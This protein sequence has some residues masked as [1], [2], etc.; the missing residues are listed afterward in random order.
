MSP[1]AATSTSS[2]DMRSDLRQS[3]NDVD[4]HSTE[5]SRRP[6]LQEMNTGQDIEKADHSINSTHPVIGLEKPIQDPNLVDFDGPEDSGNPKNWSVRKRGAATVSMGL[7]TFVVTFASSVFSVAI[8]HVAVEYNIGTVT[9]TLG[10]SLFLLGFVFG[11]VFFGPASEAYGRRVPLFAGYALF[12]IFQIPVA[13]AQN[14]ETIMLGRFFGGFFASAPLAVVGGALA[15]MWNPVERAYAV[16][17]FAAGAFVGPVFGPICGGFITQS[18][19]GWR[20]TAWLTLIMACLFGIIGLFL[21]PETSAARILQ[22]RAK[23]QRHETKNWA[24]HS[25]ADENQ[26]TLGSIFHV[27]LA[28]PWIMIAQ[29]PILALITAYLSFIYGILYLLFEAYPITFQE[30]RGWNGGV[31]SL[32]FL[33][34]VVGILMGNGVIV[35][36]TATNFKKSFIKHGKPVPEERLPPMILGAIILPIG[37]FWFAWT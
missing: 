19:L 27:Y 14:V 22:I 25:K 9:S 37:L 4:T 18:H 15:D 31:G 13:T 33:S 28:R 1:P 2:D 26:I 36:S 34:F 3:N 20:W 7:M 12:A 35:Y 21:I 11:P 10:V 30:G 5:L 17:A 8:E 16:C 6:S 24:L 23:R 29:E 32:P